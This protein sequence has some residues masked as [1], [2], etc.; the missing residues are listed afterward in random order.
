MAMQSSPSR[1]SLASYRRASAALPA[2]STA[3]PALDPAATQARPA[4]ALYLGDIFSVALEVA[5]R[6]KWQRMGAFKV[7]N[8]RDVDEAKTNLV[9]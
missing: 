7:K 2:P 6:V 8:E 3:S 4:S 5:M 9:G 1:Q